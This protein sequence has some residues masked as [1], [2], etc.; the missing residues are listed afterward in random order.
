MNKCVYLIRSNEHGYYKIGV[1]KSPQ[2]RVNS[3]QTG[4]FDTL[5]LIDKYESKFATKI[6]KSLHNLW[7]YLKVNGEW[8]ELSIDEVNNFNNMCNKIDSGFYSMESF[9]NAF[10]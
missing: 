4:N 10:L 2:N 1:S 6:E 3:L 5:T 8:F 7:G 9:N